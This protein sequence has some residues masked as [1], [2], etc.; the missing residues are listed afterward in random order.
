[1]SDSLV[2][3]IPKKE[4]PNLSGSHVKPKKQERILKQ[5]SGWLQSFFL[6]CKAHY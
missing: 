5:M 2:I 3:E 1:M 4:E 6:G